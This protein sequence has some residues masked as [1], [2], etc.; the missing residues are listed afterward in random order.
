MWSSTI[1]RAGVQHR[2]PCLYEETDTWDDILNEEYLK[3]SDA[4]WRGESGT[5]HHCLHAPE[6]EESRAMYMQEYDVC[7]IKNELCYLQYIL[8][9]HWR[10]MN[11]RIDGQ[12]CTMSYMTKRGICIVTKCQLQADQW[13]QR[14]SLVELGSISYCIPPWRCTKNHFYLF[15]APF[16]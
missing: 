8:L 9:P 2:A 6:T 4:S 3:R 16:L 10:E 13:D 5:A 14:W 7:Y 12:L 11:P 1:I 15:T